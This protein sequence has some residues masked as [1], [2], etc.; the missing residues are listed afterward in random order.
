MEEIWTDF[1]PET[2][3]IWKLLLDGEGG[4]TIRREERDYVIESRWELAV[5]YDLILLGASGL[6]E[7][8]QGWSL[9]LGQ[10]SREGE[11]YVLPITAENLENEEYREVTLRFSGAEG[12]AWAVR[13]DV[14]PLHLDPWQQLGA[15]AGG[16]V[17]KD[18]NFPGLVNDRERALMPLLGELCILNHWDLAEKGEFDELKGCIPPELHPWLERLGRDDKYVN[19]FRH[20][21][22]KGKYEDLWWSLWQTVAAT[23]EGYPVPNQGPHDRADE[24]TA[25]LHGR[26]YEGQW[27]EYRKRGMIRKNRW[28]PTG[29][30]RHPVRKGAEAVFY[31]RFGT[32]GSQLTIHCATELLNG[33]EAIGFDFCRYTLGGRR[34]M[35]TVYSWGPL[36]ERLEIALRKAELL[37]LTKQQR[38]TDGVISPLKIFFWIFLLVGG[39]AAVCFTAGM[40]LLTMVLSLL[41]AGPSGLAGVFTGL[42]WLQLFTGTWLLTGGILG[43]VVFVTV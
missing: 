35:N 19:R 24:I 23:Q 27:P 28:V 43:A 14:E 41:F 1:A 38:K 33:Q 16:I 12:R 34:F 7:E 21:M 36:E 9:W 26:G 8:C 10:L 39:F 31:I 42:P 37:P 22:T 15:V 25:Y 18:R 2:A 4:L 32:C 29:K 40:A 3:N 5:E 6:P 11:G 13:S 30:G 20:I 17:W